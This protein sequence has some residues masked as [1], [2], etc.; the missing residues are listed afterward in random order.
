MIQVLSYPYKRAFRRFLFISD[1]MLLSHSHRFIFIH[2]YKAA[3]SSVRSVLEKYTDRSAL[4]KVRAFLSVVKNNSI[5]Q[6]IGNNINSNLLAQL[7]R[8]K[9]QLLNGARASDTE[10]AN[11]RR[12]NRLNEKDIVQDTVSTEVYDTAHLKASQIKSVLPPEVFNSYFKFGFVRDPWDWQVSL[13]E[14]ALRTPAHHQHQ[15]IKSMK[16][17]TEYLQWRTQEDLQL[18]YSF[19]YENNTLLADFVGKLE[20]LEV[21]FRHV[22]DLLNIP[23]PA[24]PHRLNSQKKHYLTYYDQSAIDLVYEAFRPDIDAFGYQKPILDALTT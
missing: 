11:V 24:L 23:F 13:Y 2:N 1:S 20:D 4:Q 16:N 8:W 10:R 21:N 14:Y 5:T 18:Q 12:I 6:K 9:Y 17:F 7:D 15:K 22:C 3:G 19:F